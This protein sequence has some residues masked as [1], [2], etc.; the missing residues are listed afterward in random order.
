MA[1]KQVES[2]EPRYQTLDEAMQTA[3]AGLVDLPKTMG[4]GEVRG[5]I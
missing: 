3:A 1:R 4:S 5:H 2:M